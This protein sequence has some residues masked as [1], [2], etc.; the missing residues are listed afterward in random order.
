MTDTELL[1]LQDLQRS[2]FEPLG[3]PDQEV[4]WSN[5]IEMQF[6]DVCLP[7]NEDVDVYFH[8]LHS[9]C[10]ALLCDHLGHEPE[11][12]TETTDGFV[13]CYFSS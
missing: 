4:Y 7:Y 10:G 11:E 2:L 8:G 13:G 9:D 1:E 12:A 5:I 3:H 6:I